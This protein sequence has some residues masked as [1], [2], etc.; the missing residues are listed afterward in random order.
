MISIIAS[1]ENNHFIGLR[2]RM[3]WR[4]PEDLMWFK[5]N[6]INKPIIMGRM[7]FESIGRALPYRLNIVVSSNPVK[8]E[9]ITWARSLDEAVTISN[10]FSETMIIGGESIYKQMINDADL[11]YLTHVHVN[12]KGDKK[13]PYYNPHE[14]K[15]IFSRFHNFDK[16]NKYSC[17]FEI[18]RRYYK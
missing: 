4:L 1:F 18:L 11:L 6:T 10:T 14:W 15:L 2:N 7:T 9:N 17:N 5:K 12:I 3:M 16:K 8:S 13:F